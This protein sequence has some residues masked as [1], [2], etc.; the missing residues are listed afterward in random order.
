MDVVLNNF[1]TSLHSN[2][3]RLTWIAP[4]INS[5]YLSANDYNSLRPVAL[6][7]FEAHYLR[8]RLAIGAVYERLIGVVSEVHK[9]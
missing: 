3:Q 7:F 1:S 6:N 5:I 8:H 2:R 9:E 4:G